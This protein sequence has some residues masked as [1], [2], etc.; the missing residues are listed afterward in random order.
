[1]GYFLKLNVSYINIVALYIKSGQYLGIIVYAN[2]NFIVR[3]YFPCVMSYIKNK[4]K[5]I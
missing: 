3:F 4:I 1:M 2:T 5:T